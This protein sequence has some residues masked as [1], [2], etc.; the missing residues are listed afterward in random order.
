MWKVMGG[1]VLC[2]GLAGLTYWG[3]QNHAVA[4]EE[5]IASASAQAMQQSIHGTRV[6]V[7]A[8]DIYVTGLVDTQQEQAALLAELNN[9]NG[10]RVIVDQT[11][12]IPV[13]RPYRFEIDQAGAVSGHIPSEKTRAALAGDLGLALSNLRLS[14]GAPDE[15]WA[16]A[17]KAGW[18]ARQGLKSGDLVVEDKTVSL[19]GIAATPVEAN[20]VMAVLNNLPTGYTAKTEIDVEDDGK[21]F[22]LNATFDG[23]TANYSGKLPKEGDIILAISDENLVIARIADETGRFIN[24]AR[25]GVEALKSLQSGELAVTKEEIRLTGL[26]LTP[27]QGAEITRVL[28]AAQ[29]T[30]VTAALDF[31]DDGS[32]AKFI[33]EFDANSGA[34]LTGKLPM[35]G[36][37]EKI[38]E[39]LGFDVTAS[40]AFQ[41]FIAK[42]DADF[43]AL[44]IVREWL[45]EFETAKVTFEN[46]LR[47]LKGTLSQ[48]VDAELVTARLQEAFP[49]AEITLGAHASTPA[50]GATRVH[51][52]SGQSQIAQG[53]YWLPERKFTPNVLGCRYFE[54][55]ESQLCHGVC[56]SKCA[57]C[58]GSECDGFGAFNLL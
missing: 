32:P 24:N 3:A 41:S 39:I 34:T 19:R 57:F 51:F 5:K 52:G 14:S 12:I 17:V 27:D 47:S 13:A 7:V 48:G 4:M 56:T 54:G 30:H 43:A 23:A 8:R 16:A 10:C 11:E 20:Q 6:H 21:P 50:D 15:N 36:P 9:V 44:K 29:D 26:A 37:R 49:K 53:G 58:A 18:Q 1:L 45:P 22:L 28:D 46:G 2:T 38:V 31:I 42:G 35:D 33:L 55:H 40:D 25:L